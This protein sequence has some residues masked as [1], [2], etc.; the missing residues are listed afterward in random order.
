MN[1][2]LITSGFKAGST[3]ISKIFNCK[4]THK[5]LPDIINEL[6]N[7]DIIL[8]PFRKNEEIYKSAYFQDIIV[9]SYIYS[10]FNEQK[11]I[12]KEYNQKCSKSCSINGSNCK[13]EYNNKRIN[14][15]NNIDAK[16]LY[17]HFLS[18]EW[19]NCGHL[20]SKNIIDYTN[21]S[22]NLNIDYE[23]LKF[24]IFDLNIKNKKKKLICF[25]I[26]ILDNNFNQLL[27]I[28]NLDKNKFKLSK[29]NIGSQK[30]YSKK[31][32]EFLLINN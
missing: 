29:T 25:N 7:I 15:I 16:I 14:I 3:S 2:I 9:P 27:K 31:Y 20:N 13:C 19:D 8:L 32:K 11:G 22:F 18:F 6:N 30:W 21:K 4:K 1:N 5:S 12:F 24:Q 26:K 10:P 17:E 23:S 28:M